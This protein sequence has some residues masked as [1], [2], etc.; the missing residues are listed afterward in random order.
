MLSLIA[1][2]S[3]D[4]NSGWSLSTWSKLIVCG[5]LCAGW[6]G[7]P[8]PASAQWIK[9][10]RFRRAPAAKPAEPSPTNAYAESIRRL[11]REARQAAE[12]G[13]LVAARRAAEQAHQHALNY[14]AALSEF[15]DC[16]PEATAELLRQY[17]YSSAVAPLESVTTQQNGDD[18]ARSLTELSDESS[19]APPLGGFSKP[20]GREPRLL[21]TQEMT[22]AA[23]LPA[24]KSSSGKKKS[25]RPSAP[26]PLPAAT[27]PAEEAVAQQ[28]E[29]RYEYFQPAIQKPAAGSGTFLVEEKQFATLDSA[30]PSE[31]KSKETAVE[32]PPV[33]EIA[34]DAPSPEQP[35]STEA[36]EQVPEVVSEPVTLLEDVTP[37]PSAAV[38]TLDGNE[39][40]QVEV[41]LETTAQ[42]D[43]ETEWPE[44]L[45][46]EPEAS[47][48]SAEEQ[49][50]PQS[51]EPSAVAEPPAAETAVPDAD[52]QAVPE[53]PRADAESIDSESEFFSA[54][55]A[56]TPESAEQ[57]EQTEM[58]HVTYTQTEPSLPS[59]PRVPAL[60]D[61]VPQELSPPK[62]VQ[63]AKP[64]VN[65]G[66]GVA[67]S[68][69]LVRDDFEEPAP[70]TR[71]SVWQ[72]FEWDDLDAEEKIAVGGGL[73]LLCGIVLFMASTR[74][75]AGSA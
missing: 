11:K 24:K 69:T 67:V 28:P 40:L 30:P 18:L 3:F 70:R 55:E 51:A 36:A 26:R 21:P 10:D 22:A 58:T 43:N 41:D 37:V 52:A 75:S 9:L 42:R 12:G 64:S 71:S 72:Q 45:D 17:A 61:A 74:R 57:I 48:S 16:A 38:D 14:R 32:S 50:A 47:R 5:G 33:Q 4:D 49:P 25:R 20:K 54:P 46:S 23:Q 15:P 44:W 35:I 68:W 63:P 8:Q 56:E 73:F 19:I 7:L 1:P 27:T 62:N 60:R 6:L 34:A 29:P 13:D 39:A 53:L 65:Y 66:E 31:E 59:A 2:K